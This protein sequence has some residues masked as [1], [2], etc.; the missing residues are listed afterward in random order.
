[1]TELEKHENEVLIEKMRATKI[2]NLLLHYIEKTQDDFDHY[3]CYEKYGSAK[4]KKKKYTLDKEDLAE[5]SKIK[6]RNFKLVFKEL[7]EKATEQKP[8]LEVLSKNDSNDKIRDW[9]KSLLVKL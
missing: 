7:F 4:F 6:S 8:I 9:A 1:M 2:R 3:L 5:Q